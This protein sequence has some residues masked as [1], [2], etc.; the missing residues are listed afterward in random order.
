MAYGDNL[1]LPADHGEGIEMRFKTPIRILP[2]GAPQSLAR[3]SVEIKN[4]ASAVAMHFLTEVE[5]FVQH[6]LWDAPLLQA[7]AGMLGE[8]EH[9]SFPFVLMIGNSLQ[10][11]GLT[12]CARMYSS[13]D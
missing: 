12:K 2:A 4:R 6:V 3:L 11:Q 13:S 7:G 1:P 9:D 5:Q 10:S 8:G